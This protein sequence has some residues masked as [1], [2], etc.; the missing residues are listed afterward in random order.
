MVMFESI[1][2]NLIKLQY[3]VLQDSKQT[4]CAEHNISE[5]LLNQAIID[6][7][8]QIKEPDNS[9]DFLEKV[10]QQ[11]VHIATQ[12]QQLTAPLYTK[13]EYTILLKCLEVVKTIKAEDSRAATNLKSVALI[14][15][16]LLK[17]NDILAPNKQELADTIIRT[18]TKYKDDSDEALDK[19]IKELEAQLAN[20]GL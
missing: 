13:I 11:A 7:K 18:L 4:I 14:I 10:E 16:T 12:R 17:H 15:D 1:N 20:H 19:R 8:W 2:W 3:E 6:N 5:G 9:N